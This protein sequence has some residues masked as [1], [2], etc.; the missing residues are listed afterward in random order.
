MRKEVRQRDRFPATRFQILTVLLLGM[1]LLFPATLLPAA[2]TWAAVPGVAGIEA[3]KRSGVTVVGESTPAVDV[4]PLSE[5]KTMYTQDGVNVRA[6]AG[7]DT[8]AIGKLA[9]GSEVTVT[10][11]AG[12]W[13]AVKFDDGTGFIKSEF[14]SEEAPEIEAVYQ[15]NFDLSTL[16]TEVEDFG[17]SR[18]NLDENNV[19]TDWTWY[20]NRWGQFNVDWIQDTGKKTIYLTMD[21]GFENDTTAQI[22]DTLKEKN[23][24]AVFFLTKYFVDEM[25]DTVQRMIDEGHQ[26][27]NHSCTHP[28][29]PEI[30]LEEQKDQVLTLQNLVKDKFGYTMKYFRYPEGAFSAQSLGLVNNLGLKVVFWSYAYNDY[31]DEEPPVAES[32]EKAVDAV[33]PGAV[34]LLHASSSTNAAFLG[35][36]IDACRAK[37]YEFGVYPADAN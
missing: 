3:Y 26:L 9:I 21:E 31:S 18:K 16:S 33:H 11:T 13:S 37:G 12:E 19:P 35:D 1:I 36:W 28:R 34:Y 4:T 20:E 2:N 29:M 6:G 30:S 23:V 14:L 10:G 8:E 5:P 22:L 27:G 17:Y 25:P 7:T 15:G 32:L 24:K